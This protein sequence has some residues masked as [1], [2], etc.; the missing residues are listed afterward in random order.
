MSMHDEFE[1]K[2]SSDANKYVK[3]SRELMLLID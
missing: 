2:L 1:L 3:L